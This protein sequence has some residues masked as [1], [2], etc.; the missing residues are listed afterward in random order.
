MTEQIVEKSQEEARRLFRS[1]AGDFDAWKRFEDTVRQIV[2]SRAWRVIGYENFGEAWKGEN[3]HRCPQEAKALAITVMADEGLNTKFGGGTPNGHTI[4]SIAQAIGYTVQQ[5]KGGPTCA[6]V[7]KIL[8][9]HRYGVPPDKMLSTGNGYDG[10]RGVEDNIAEHGDPE[11]VAKNPPRKPKKSPTK[12]QN[13][14][15]GK[16]ESEYVDDNL[17]V[18]KWQSRAVEALARHYG[19]GYRVNGYR[20]AIQEMLSKPEYREVWERTVEEGVWE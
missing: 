2:S 8:R 20:Q 15:T 9:Q 6:T 3:G 1:A 14:R 16:S 11:L 13:R 17:S 18:L 10:N 5:G 19:W 4:G 12:P 7:S